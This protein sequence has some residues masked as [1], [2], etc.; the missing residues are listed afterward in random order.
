M[1][2]NQRRQ[3]SLYKIFDSLSHQRR[4]VRFVYVVDGFVGYYS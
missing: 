3:Q 1:T 4:D 2:K